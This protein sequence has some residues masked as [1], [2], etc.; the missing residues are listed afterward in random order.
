MKKF[1]LLTV[2]TLF[3]GFLAAQNLQP[4]KPNHFISGKKAGTQM[5]AKSSHIKMHRTSEA[6]V[7][8]PKVNLLTEGFE[9]CP[10]F[11]PT[12]WMKTTTYSPTWDTSNTY[13]HSGV[14]GAYCSW[15]T[16]NNQD[17]R[18]ITPVLNFTGITH[19]TLKFWFDASMYWAVTPYDNY[20]F[21][22]L[23]ST[24]GGTTW[25]API[26]SEESDT[27]AWDSWTWSEVT[28]GLDAYAGQSN[29]K[30]AF[31]YT[32]ND[33]AD[34]GLDDISVYD[35]P[36]ADA[37]VMVVTSPL[38]GCNLGSTEQVIVTVKNYGSNPISNIPVHY[39]FNNGATVDGTCTATIAAG[40]TA[41]YTFTQTVNASTFGVDS[42][43]AWTSL[44]SDGNAANDYAP[45][46]YFAN[47]QPT[48]PPMSMGFEASDDLL[49]YLIIDNNADGSTWQIG[50]EPTLS[51]SGDRFMYY[52]YNASN[53]A[54]D[55]AFT[56][57]VNLNP[58]SYTF[59]FWYRAHAAEYPEAVEAKYGS[60]Q[61]I[62]GMTNN[63]TT[64][65]NIAD[66][67]YQHSQT[68]FTIAT[69]GTYYFGLHAI[70]DA[71]MWHLFVDDVTITASGM[72]V[73]ENNGAVIN[74]Y[75]NPVKDIL[76]INST[77]NIEE[78]YMMNTLGQTV[79]TSRV[80][81]TN[82]TINTADFNEGV[83]FIR[84]KTAN[85]YKTHK[86]IVN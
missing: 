18:L 85:G 48:S 55:W 30:L 21:N 7:N 45:T 60:A 47:I 42:I 32:G 52:T 75:P 72:G 25:S 73:E 5:E 44:S 1:T 74:L 76:Y 86:V 24:N 64:I 69:A 28:I 2:F 61:T 29:V 80:D 11:P 26:W 50:E 8:G 63:L 3:V 78:L 17:E 83:Y 57:C 41:S 56:K 6:A 49:G 38:S 82:F 66:T 12:G 58:G 36:T 33:G 19:P 15:Q 54:D 67:V 81:D 71:D 4:L 79:Y 70:S 13:V 68:Q 46:Y 62:A 20:D 51:H 53:A 59:G 23:I 39:K 77:D 35:V 84:M 10:P 43:V 14:L 9:G 27:S 37:G 40:A 65:S 34:L 22:V 31:Q 16:G